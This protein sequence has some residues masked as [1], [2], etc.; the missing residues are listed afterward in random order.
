MPGAHPKVADVS[1]VI[2]A[3]ADASVEFIVIGGAAGLLHG[4]PLFTMDVDVVHRRTLANVA[5]LLGLL[6]SL[7]AV[8][9]LDHRGLRAEASHLMGR[10]AILQSTALG[11]LDLLC[12]LNDGRGYDDLLAHSVEIPVLARTVRVLDLATLIEVKTS[13]GREKDK[14]AVAHLLAILRRD[15]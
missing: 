4:S 7:D 3:L 5:R 11:P 9:R 10:G 15:A 6:Q 8:F 1:A 2:A 12:E 14:L 13:A